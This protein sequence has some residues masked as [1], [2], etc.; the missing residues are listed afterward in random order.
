MANPS[1]A[2]DSVA[3]A[4]QDESAMT[5]GEAIHRYPTSIFWALAMSFTIVMVGYD[6]ILMGS[7]MA[8][9][10]FVEKYGTYHPE[11]GRY[12]I[13]G[14]WQVG[15]TVTSSCSG[16]IGLLCSGFLT[17]RFGHRVVTMGAL[18]FLAGFIFIPFFAPN[19]HALIAGQFLLGMPWGI[20]TIMGTAYS[21]EICPTALRGYLTS[22]SNLCW[23][24]GQFIVAG[25][26]QGLVDTN[27]QWAFRI[28]FAVEWV[29]PVPLLLIAL[30]APDS[31]WWL[32]RRGRLE[33]A[34]A[35]LRRLS[36]GL[37]DEELEK[38]ILMMHHTN[39][40]EQQVQANVSFLDCFRGVNLRRTEISCL[41]LS[42]QSLIG[43]A[44]AYNATYFFVQ[45]GLSPSNAYKMNLADMGIAF[46]A[47]MFSWVLMSW[48]GRRTL[49]V[50][51]S[52]MLTLVLLLIGVLSFAEDHNAAKWGQSGLAL[53][54]IAIYS[55][56]IGP[57]TFALA[58]EVS[59]T[60][61]R[62]QTL[63]ITGIVYSAVNIVDNTVEPYLIN[64]TEG[65]LKGKAAFVWFGV[66]VLVT[67]WGFFRIP[68]TK[69]RTFAELDVLFENKV[70]AWRF[71]SEKVDVLTEVVEDRRVRDSS[72]TSRD[73][74][75]VV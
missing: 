52:S 33:D 27:T 67:I 2:E 24:I 59:A 14:P 69:G 62:S 10:S 46:A 15:L 19:I 39:Q 68:E 57:Q 23:V 74:H 32:V 37:T 51:G 21:S 29:F 34:K 16:I 12:V 66:G 1:L 5:V 20:F 38:K 45:A 58:S 63:S 22:F 13:S 49:I 17:E 4:Y 42:S 30:L 35:S 31:P 73:L 36:S 11:L 75:G 28:P 41:T 61:L 56:T 54:W 71:S 43:Q 64:P 55:A 65:N 44:L 72:G 7:L 47:T 6:T 18:T 70:P 3:R 40:L 26:L 9:P 25:I 8:Y 53:V 60:R 50:F 48:F